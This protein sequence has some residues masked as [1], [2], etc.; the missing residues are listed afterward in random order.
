[1]VT[2]ND[3]DVTTKI[4]SKLE[5]KNKKKKPNTICG[6]GCTYSLHQLGLEEVNVGK[7][8]W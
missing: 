4:Y 7:E 3:R 6:H 5:T 2:S 1:M 8:D